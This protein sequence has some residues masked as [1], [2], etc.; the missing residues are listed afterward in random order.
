MSSLLPPSPTISLS[1][2]IRFFFRSK[3]EEIMSF[4][5][6]NRSSHLLLMKNFNC[7]DV[8]FCSSSFVIVYNVL[9]RDRNSI[10]IS[11]HCVSGE[12]ILK[13]CVVKSMLEHSIEIL[14]LVSVIQKAQNFDLCSGVVLFL[15]VMR[16][17]IFDTYLI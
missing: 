12:S 2:Q 15:S 5:L 9:S 13:R 11:S 16:I 3:I 6:L 7:S 10:L 8:Y 4:L 14:L 1:I 17:R